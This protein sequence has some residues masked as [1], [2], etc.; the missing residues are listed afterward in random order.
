MII[1]IKVLTV[2]Q[3]GFGSGDGLG[4]ALFMSSGSSATVKLCSFETNSTLGGSGGNTFAPGAGRGGS[5]F[6][7][8]VLQVWSSTF[9]GDLSVGGSTAGLSGGSGAVGQG[10]AICSIGPLSV[11]ASTFDGN[12]AIGGSIGF[13]DFGPGG[14]GEGGAVWTTS[15]LW[16]TNSTI[17]AN[18]G[19]GGTNSHQGWPGGAGNGGG[20]A[21]TGGTASLVNITVAANRVDATASN[22]G[23][24]PLQGGGIYSTNATVII[25]DSIVADSTSG[26]DVWGILTDDGYNICSDS[27]AA[28]S[29]E[30]SLNNTEPKLGPL[31]DY[32]GPTLT[33]ALLAG[34]P[35]IDGGG[36]AGAPSTDQRGR[37]RPFGSG[38]DIGAFESSPPYIL[39]GSVYGF[40]LAD[41]VSVSTRTLTNTTTDLGHFRFDGFA[42]GTYSLSAAH[43]NYVFVPS[44]QEVTVGPDKLD[45]TFHAFRWHDLSPEP[46]TNGQSHLVLAATPGTTWRIL[47]S[48]N[49]QDWTTVFTNTIGLNSI[50]DALLPSSPVQSRLYRAV[51]P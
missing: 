19:M 50:L 45:L 36:P 15:Q 5:V 6:N 44:S 25:R 40:T 39:A 37:T 47:T 22:V 51:T 34:S 8:G 31:R 28:F 12:A 38:V 41:E 7:A 16:M 11:N 10:G 42:S 24:A 46:I 21:L 4:G 49:T 14:A 2:P 20:I 35:A 26:A 17:A 29:A 27:T 30:G 48:T 23:P 32:G 3:R 18:R 13:G 33:M 9:S 1:S 43:S